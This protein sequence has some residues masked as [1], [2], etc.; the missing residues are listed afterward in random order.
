MYW[1]SGTL[2]LGKGHLSQEVAPCGKQSGWQLDLRMPGE[3]VSLLGLAAA[4]HWEEFGR[5]NG[6][7]WTVPEVAL[8]HPW[9][10]SVL[11]YS[12]APRNS[13]K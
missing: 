1:I 4:G 5:R 8:K 11:Q 6:D 10:I 3:A 13:R 9:G 2:P 7:Y 12:E